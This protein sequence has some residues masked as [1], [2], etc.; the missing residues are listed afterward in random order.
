MGLVPVLLG[1]DGLHDGA[2]HRLVGLAHAGQQVALE[3][4][5]A[6]L[7]SGAQDLARSSFQP[8]MGIADDHLH[9]AQATTRE[10]P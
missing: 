5:A 8:L 2:D 3:M 1:E 6:T 10:R 4:Y 9:A 7:P